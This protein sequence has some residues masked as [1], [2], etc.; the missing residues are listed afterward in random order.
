MNTKN[1]TVI[2]GYQFSTWKAALKGISNEP[3]PHSH[4]AAA[5]PTKPI[6][7]KTRWPVPMQQQHRGKHENRDVFRTHAI[8]LPSAVATSLK[9]VEMACRSIRKTPKVMMTLIGHITGAQAV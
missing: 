7:P 4:N 9:K 6:T 3:F 8:G 1:G 2:S 5:A